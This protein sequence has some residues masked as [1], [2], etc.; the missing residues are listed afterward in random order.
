[1]HTE[2][3]TILFVDIAG[4]TATTNRQSR[5]Q[6]ASLLQNF[7]NL[8]K[9]QIKKF[10]GQLVKSIGDALLL[11]FRSP[12]DAMLCACRMQDRVAW[13]RQQHP[14]DE[15]I[16]I[17][18]A[19][20]LGEVRVARHDV[21][22][23]AVNLAARIEA[24]TPPGEIYLSEAVYLAMNK[25]EVPVQSAGQFQLDGFSHPLT[26]YQAMASNSPGDLRFG[27]DSAEFAL[28]QHPLRRWLWLA[29]ALLLPVG[30]AGYF[31]WQDTRPLPPM[32]T[33]LPQRQASQFIRLDLSALNT[34][35]LSPAEKFGLTHSLQ[36]AIDR[37]S[38]LYLQT[39]DSDTK[40]K[41]SISVLWR[42]G[43]FP[44]PDQLEFR[45]VTA[46]TERTEHWS[47]DWQH[48][49]TAQN[50][51]QAAQKMVEQLLAAGPF[52]ELFPAEPVSTIPDSFFQ[53]YLLALSNLEQG[54]QTQDTRLID[55]A[56]DSLQHIHQTVP[57]FGPGKR[58]LCHSLSL[59]FQLTDD[60]S[61][62]QR[63]G[64]ICQSLQLPLNSVPDLLAYGR[65]LALADNKPAAQKTL[66]SVLAR[67]PKS[68]EAYM[69]LSRLYLADK[70]PLEAELVLKRA[71]T[72]QPDYWPAIQLMALFQLERG[73]LSAAI[74]HL[75]QVILLTPDNATALTNL[76]S[77]YLLN[78]QLQAAADTYQQALQKS[79]EPFIQAN[80]AT[81]Y[82]YL[83]R[84]KDAIRLYQQAIEQ[85]QTDFVLHG[86]IAD[87]YRQ[88]K[89][90]AEAQLH[91][92]QAITLLKNRTQP[93]ARALALQ[94]HYLVQL[95]RH[96]EA[97]DVMQQALAKNAETAEV[98][99]LDALLKTRMGQTTAAVNSARQALAF[100]YPAKLL[101][102]DPDLQL[103]ASD[104]GFLALLH[105][106][107]Q[108]TP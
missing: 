46:A 80:L 32:L 91:Y 22:G 65:Y 18:I 29:A 38:G 20:H 66:L 54:E 40:A 12:T 98:W 104:P 9:P 53:Q 61:L 77:A 15:P 10:S 14:Q 24:V 7:E 43:V 106:Q 35:Q 60:A 55:K 27:T 94:A 84:M 3:L 1:V 26:L 33:E 37:L 86:N 96:Q 42:D 16:V 8:L 56:S 63:A 76:G 108:E 21:F 19:A 68:G 67:N 78:G 81:V 58:A 50:L 48:Q 99:L 23:E 73:Q 2:N 71:I 39:N 87:A 5:R 49:M 4:F 100:G 36:Q 101:A 79:P 102:V 107:P 90:P 97:S 41:Y 31:W 74:D 30:F 13:H 25:T 52:T 69:L 51:Q 44:Q 59:L 34:A 57:Q 62:L 47:L 105:P 70:Q 64:D 28:S 85:N 72:V 11:T 75:Q 45:L 17:R 103:L 92:Q 6:N 82:Y 95:D 83:G 88:N 93:D 89:Q